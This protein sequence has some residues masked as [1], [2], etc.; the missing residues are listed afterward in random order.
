MNV[1][2]K[3]KAEE[4]IQNIAEFVDDMNVAGAEGRWAE[5]FIEHVYK[6]GELESLKFPLC[7]NESLAKEGIAA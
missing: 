1:I 2:F 5:K 3:P 4:T 6:V 7:N